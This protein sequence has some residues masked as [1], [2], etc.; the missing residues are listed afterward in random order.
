MK[1]KVSKENRLLEK[2][3]KARGYMFPEWEYVIEKDPEF[4]E[5]Y[6]NL[7]QKCL[8]DGKAL[9]AKTRELIA[10]G[11][12]AFRGQESAVLTHARRALKLG[13]TREEILEAIETAFVPGG[14]PTLR[15]GLSALLK[16]G[17]K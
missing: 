9:P 14:G 7:Y 13:A 3:K 6:N 4:F 16:L 15:V 17:K 2:A 5:A 11:I 12:L 10:I 1:D 8:T